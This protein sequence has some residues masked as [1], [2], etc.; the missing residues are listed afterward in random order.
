MD[1]LATGPPEV[2]PEDLIPLVKPELRPGER[3]LWASR[4]GVGTSTTPP[5]PS[6]A[7]WT[8][9]LGFLATSA[10]CLS[11]VGYVDKTNAGSAV[12]LLMFIGLI[13]GL[14]VFFFAIGFSVGLANRRVARRKHLGQVYALTDQRAII[15]FPGPTAAV[16]IHTFQRGTVKAEDLH[17]VQYPDGSGDVL[18]RKSYQEPLGF[19]GVTEVRRVEELVRT[20]LVVP[21]Q[22]PIHHDAESELY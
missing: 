12:G 2:I 3:L 21:G 1:E 10:G 15:W 16:S 19:L 8:W 6:I 22:Q 9:F 4:A 13:S 18:L 7:A 14:I 17:R 5:G 11:A 20:F